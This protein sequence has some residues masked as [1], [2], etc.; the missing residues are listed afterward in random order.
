MPTGSQN[1]WSTGPAVSSARA[2]NYDLALRQYMLSVYNYMAAGLATTGIVALLAAYTGFY[3]AIIGTPLMY[4]VM[5]APLGLVMLMSFRINH[6]SMASA[7]GLFWLY[8]AVNGLSLSA[9]FLIYTHNSI[10]ETFFITSATFGAMSLWGYTTKSSLDGMG[11]FLIMGLFGIII[12]GLVNFFLQSNGLH[13]V[14]SVLG[15]LIFTGLTAYDTQKIKEAFDYADVG[16][17]GKVAL[18]GA[19]TLY[20]DFIN[21]FLMLLRFVGDRRND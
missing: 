17:R 7:Q 11:N 20:L 1:P 21:L 9:I 14:I 8:S 5:F 3:Q 15:V 18:M 10:A 12:A 16:A 13:F 6:M 2:Q 19:L 4:L